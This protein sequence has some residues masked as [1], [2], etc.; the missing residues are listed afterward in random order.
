MFTDIGLIKLI[1]FRILEVDLD[2]L[3][4]FRMEKFRITLPSLVPEIF[5]VSQRGKY[6][7]LLTY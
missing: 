6:N 2:V 5:T 3:D 7:S 1:T 4:R